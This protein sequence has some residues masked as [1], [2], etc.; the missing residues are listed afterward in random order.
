MLII[1][2][3]FPNLSR[4]YIIDTEGAAESKILVTFH[5][6]EQ[7]EEGETS[8]ETREKVFFD[9]SSRYSGFEFTKKRALQ[10]LAAIVVGLIF[11]SLPIAELSHEAKIAFGIL[12]GSTVMFMTQCLPQGV[13]TLTIAIMTLATG[14]LNMGEFQTNFGKSPF[15]MVMALMVVSAGMKHTQLAQRITYFFIAKLG[16]SR[17]MLVLAILFSTSL[18]SVFI[19]DLATLV[20]IYPIVLKVLEELGEKPGKSRLGKAL[21]LACGW[22]TYI[23]GL[24][25]MS[26]NGINVTGV[27][28]LETAS[29]GA[30]TVSYNQWAMIGIPFAL[31]MQIPAWLVLVAVF[32]VNK[33]DPDAPQVN[34]ALFEQ[35]LR[36]LGPL[37]AAEKRFLATVFLM[38]AMFL[39]GSVIPMFSSI[40]LVSFIAMA[41]TIA[42]VVGTV[43]WKQAQKE[44]NWDVLLLIGFVV[45]FAGA[46]TKTGLGKWMVEL[47]LGQS[48]SWAIWQIVLMCGIVGTLVHFVVVANG[49]GAVAILLA[50]VVPIATAA[51]LNPMVMAL[52]MLFTAT[53]GLVSP[54]QVTYFI[55]SESGYYKLSEVLLP[56]TLL[57]IVWVLFLTFEMMAVGPILGLF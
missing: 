28:M 29:E 18:I 35:R 50:G 55:T 48:T 51:G 47:V 7:F 45:A 16:S 37:N 9:A 4:C 40:P 6:Q 21:L 10:L 31:V 34:R 39:S 52:P 56:A 53:V 3:Y 44:I 2:K 11:Y 36:D 14:I 23:G 8:M 22:G 17:S 32:K 15:M 33:V 57:G 30:V 20:L 24:A 54:I 25:L 19:S 42:P 49:N 26:G 27:T 46:I 38:V 43:N 1:F 12:A 5:N 13:I 41:I